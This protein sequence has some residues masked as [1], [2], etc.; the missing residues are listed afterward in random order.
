MQVEIF[1]GN[2]GQVF[3]VSGQLS[4]DGVGLEGADELGV[5]PKARGDEEEAVLV[6]GFRFADVYGAFERPG[7]GLGTNRE[8]SNL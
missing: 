8:G 3:E 5:D 1:E 7:K 4:G 2:L 6:A